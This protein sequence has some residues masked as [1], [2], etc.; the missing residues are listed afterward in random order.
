MPTRSSYAKKAARKKTG[1]GKKGAWLK[2]KS[3]IRLKNTRIKDKS[4]I[5]LA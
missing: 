3:K 2:D 5:A 4:R 1:K